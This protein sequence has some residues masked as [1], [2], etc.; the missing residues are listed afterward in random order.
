MT[1]YYFSNSIIH[2]GNNNHPITVTFFEGKIKCLVEIDG[3]LLVGIFDI[4]I[5]LLLGK[6]GSV[7]PVEQPCLA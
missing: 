2:N 1:N 7:G 6:T 5:F 3:I 4:I